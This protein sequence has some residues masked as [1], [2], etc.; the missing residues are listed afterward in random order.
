[1]SVNDIL[2]TTY[3]ESLMG[4][5]GSVTDEC[6]RRGQTRITS[7][8]SSAN[9]VSQESDAGFGGR[10]AIVE[11]SGGSTLPRLRW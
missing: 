4:Y 1:M 11:H 5:G 10:L 7:R 8:D 6:P 3:D 2:S 9:K